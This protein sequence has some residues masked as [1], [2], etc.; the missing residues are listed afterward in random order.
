MFTLLIGLHA[1]KKDDAQ[2]NDSLM[3][4]VYLKMRSPQGTDLLN[5]ANAGQINMANT[6]LYY[7]VDNQKVE[8]FKENLDFPKGLFIH[9]DHSSNEYVVEVF[10]NHDVANGEI[11]TN[12]LE[13]EGYAPDTIQVKIRKTEGS[14][15][16]EKLWLSGE[17]ISLEGKSQTDVIIKTPLE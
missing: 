6:R 8:F 3:S 16:Y 13:Y 10:L 1:C 5:P 15:G 7:M 4:K 9:K 11:S 17:E 14:I 12:I 2:G